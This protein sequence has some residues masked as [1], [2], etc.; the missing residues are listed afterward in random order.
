MG[1]EAE[2]QLMFD[3]RSVPAKALLETHEL[4]LRG[5][6]RRRIQIVELE[7]VHVAGD[8]LLFAH[9]GGD[10]ALTLPPGQADK[11]L[12]KITTPAPSL[13]RKL[14]IDTDHLA[15]VIGTTDDPAVTAALEGATTGDYVQASQAVVIADSPQ[16]LAAGLAQVVPHGLPVWIIYPKGAASS[17]PES[18]VR[19]HLRALNY[20]DIKTSGV[21]DRLTALKFSLRRS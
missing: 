1:L 9:D 3:G 15:L 20:V 4:I 16:D 8:Q 10:Y 19:T 11:W 6:V 14:G 17:L 5:E 21:S 13:A 12:R 7:D 18:A 2:S